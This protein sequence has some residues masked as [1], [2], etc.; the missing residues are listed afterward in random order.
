MTR[1]RRNPGAAAPAARQGRATA[2]SLVLVPLLLAGCDGSQEPSDQGR[3]APAPGIVASSLI[4]YQAIAGATLVFISATPGAHEGVAE[5]RLRLERTGEERLV[6]VAGGG[7]DPV[8]LMAEEGDQVTVAPVSSAGQAAAIAVKKRSPP[9]VVRVSTDS[10][11][12]DVPLNARIE[13]VFS[14]PIDLESA[15]EGI[16]LTSPGGELVPIDV[17]VAGPGY[18]LLLDPLVEL[19]PSTAYTITIAATVRDEAG[20]QVEAPIEE[21]FRTGTAATGP[22]PVTPGAAV[23]Y[24][25]VEDDLYDGPGYGLET[26]RAAVMLVRTWAQGEAEPSPALVSRV[27]WTTSN[28]DVAAVDVSGEYLRIT[29]LRAG[30][31]QLRAVADQA[32]L[33]FEVLVFDRVATPLPASW[34][35]VGVQDGRLVRMNLDGTGIEVLAEGVFDPDVGPDGRIVYA[36]YDGALRLR[37]ADGTTTQLAGPR[38]ADVTQHCPVLSPDGAEVAFLR[39]RWVYGWPSEDH[40]TVVVA[41]VTGGTEREVAP[42]QPGRPC[43]QWRNDRDVIVDGSL[44]G[45]GRPAVW[46]GPLSPTS[47]HRLYQGST[48]LVASAAVANPDGSSLTYLHHGAANA[49]WTYAFPASWSPDG[50][51][52]LAGN[53]FRGTE[54]VSLDGLRHRALPLPA[55]LHHARLVP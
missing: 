25:A 13:V 4:P 5:V 16:T 42:E 19:E 37:A 12:N 35:V 1:H 38:G 21:T 41:S 48:S 40:S 2:A 39:I 9:R 23:V 29:A 32:S 17:T 11:K 8:A 43:P 47:A 53:R 27:R 50:Q 55:G 30:R 10:P 34:R 33:E 51:W 14:A 20:A 36:S 6:T 15:R 7:W 46:A 45:P 24:I 44:S 22:G 52:V 54:L 26:G 18:R 3:P 31:T 49:Y 28:P